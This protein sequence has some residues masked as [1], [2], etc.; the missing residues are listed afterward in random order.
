MLNYR[1]ERNESEPDIQLEENSKPQRT[2]LP[3]DLKP[4]P[5]S[6][7]AWQHLRQTWENLSFRTKLTILLFSSTALPVIAVTHGLIAFDKAQTIR[8]LQQSLQQQGK[9]FDEEYVLGTQVDSQVKAE[10]LAKLIQATEVNLSNPKEVLAHRD[11]LQDFL[12]IENGPDP[13]VNKNFQIFTDSQGRIVAQDIKVLDAD[14]SSNPPLPDLTKALTEQRY[15]SVSLPLGTY[16]GDIPIVK[17]ALRTGHPLDGIELLKGELLQRLGLQKQADIGLQT[18]ATHNLSESQRPSPQGTYDIDGGKAGLLGMAVYPIKVKNKLVGTVIVGS[19]LNRNYGL[20][21]KFSQKYKVPLVSVFAQD[22]RVSTN[23]P[24][25]DGQTRAIGTR[26]SQE[27]AASVLNHG[28]DF[29]G[30]ANIIGKPALTF[31]TPLYDHQ[32]ELNPQA[33]PIGMAFVG[34]SSDQVESRLRQQQLIG[35]GLG[36]SLSLLFGLIAIPT[37][38]SFSR[39]LR[40]LTSYA[41][42][43]GA[44]EQ[45]AQLELT[46]RQ[47]EIGILTQELSQ[48]A[49]SIFM[50]EESLKEEN[51][52]KERY[53]YQ[54]QLYAEIAGHRVGQFQDAE[55]IFHQAATGARE[56][57]KADR[58][59]VYLFQP[60]GHRYIVAESVLPDWPRA[61]EDKNEAPPLAAQL[62]EAYRNGLV[63]PTNNVFEAGFDPEHLKLMELLQVKASLVTPIQKNEQLFGLLVAHHC[64]APHNWQQ[65]EI[66]FFSQLANQIGLVLD[67]V[68]LI[69]QKSAEAERLRMLREITVKIGRSVEFEAVL[70]TAVEETRLALNADRVV[71]Y[72]LLDKWL[73][74]VLAES[75]TPGW[76]RALGSQI[77]DPCFHQQYAERYRA[78]RVKATDNIYNAGLTDCHIKQLEAFAVKAN[79]VAPIM[80]GGE[81]LG[82]LIAHQCSG[83]RTWQQSEI[84]LFTQIATQMGYALDLATLVEQQKVAKEQLQQR[85]LELLME[86]EPVSQGD[87]TIRASVTDDEIGTVADS[88]N[89]TVGSLRKIVTQVQAVARAVATT[90]SNNEV[91]VAELSAEALRQAEEIAA[92]LGRI[93]EVSNSIQAV[94]ASAEQAEDMVQQATRTVEQGDMAMNRTVEGILAIR[95]TVAETSKKVQRLGESSQKISKVVN[96]IGRFAAQTNLLALKAS[97]EAARAGDEG[98]GFAVLAEEVRTLAGQSAAATTEIESLVATIQTETQEVV[99]AMEAGTEQV[100]IGTKLVDETRNSLNHITAASTQIGTLVEVIAQ[101]AVSQSQASVAVTQAIT[102]VAEIANKNSTE[103]TSVSASF[104]ELLAVAQQ[105]EASVGQF[106]V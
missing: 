101:A 4:K 14:T 95:E 31:Y 7:R 6:R 79:L 93:Q 64:S 103:A 40:R 55:P 70:N 68:S 66:S 102:N 42:Q 26:A 1:L 57:L 69:E 20:V 15:R 37:A 27:V 28:Q 34:V 3:P 45:V 74:T 91:S 22:W 105:L 87:L 48:L 89:A 2:A 100:V 71:V 72:G 97:I 56:I 33:K 50:N 99:A 19:L 24:Y 67:R 18:Q 52:R 17:D 39:P 54:S 16:L 49:D 90:T 94:A 43:V 36:G 81:L 46:G 10:Q 92:A 78:G 38:A 98:R 61:A 9:A 86:V 59:V 63:F 29:S 13:E 62:M 73:K 83:P 30:S 44:R 8:D 41:K 5:N 53:S 77:N 80:R 21:D 51:R 65:Y 11:L 88:Y 85:A 96:L 12:K 75:V 60:D 47:D 84:D 82:L 106:K 35:Y 32:Q 23:V 104:K 76:P 25:S 58:V